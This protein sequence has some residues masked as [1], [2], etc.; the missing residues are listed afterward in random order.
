LNQNRCLTKNILNH[1]WPALFL[2]F[3]G[4]H[5]QST[6]VQGK[7]FSDRSLPLPFSSILLKGTTTGTTANT[8]GE[9][10]I[11]LPPGD[12][13]LIA[14][15]V[16][17]GSE[18]V[19]VHVGKDSVLLNF[20]LNLQQLTLDMITVKSGQEDPAYAIIREAIKKRPYYR[21]QEISYQC[22]VYTKGQIRLNSYPKIF[23]GQRIDFGD[24]GPSP[25]KM[26]YLSET[27]ARYTV[28][29]PDKE[30]I[31]VISTRVSGQSNGFGFSNPKV[32]SFYDNH[33]EITQNVNP[34]GFIS[35]IAEGAL[36]YYKYKY[37]GAFFEDGRQINRIQVIPK[38]DYEPLFSGYI[39][40]VEGEWRIHSL[41]LQL[42]K[43]S[44]LEFLRDI[45][46][47]Q[48]YMQV[49]GDI[50]MIQSQIVYPTVS[51]M[52]FDGH[53]FFTSVFSN[54]L[55]S[56]PIKKGFFD[57]T[58]I[59]YDS[60]SNK[61]DPAFWSALRPIPLMEDEVKDFNMKD[62]LEQKRAD[63]HY[64]D[65]LDKIRNKLTPV[66]LLLNGQELSRHSKGTGFQYDPLLKV[67]SF[68]TVEGWAIQLA[69]TWTKKWEGRR[70]L[71]ISPVIRYGLNNGHFNPLVIGEYKYG[72]KYVNTW[73]FS[74][75][76]RIFQFNNDNPIPQVMNTLTTLMD[77]RNY[78]KIYEAK[79]LSAEYTRGIGAGFT[80]R[81][82]FQYQ[83]RRPLENTDTTSYWGR[84]NNRENLTPN[85]PTEIA[86]SNM[87]PHEAFVLSAELRYRPGTR[88]IEMPDR[89]INIGS[90]YP[91]FTLRLDKGI[92]GLFG[93][94]VDFTKWQFTVQQNIN[95]KIPGEIR[96][97]AEWGGF[98]NKARAEIPDYI[99][100]NGNLTSKAENYLN[101]FQLLPYYLKSG[102][103]GFY[104]ALHAEH[105]F[106][107][108]L[109]NKIPYAKRL[110][111][112]LIAGTNLLWVGP[113]NH[114][115]ECFV[116]L[117]NIL[118]IFRV[119]YVWGWTE[120]GYYNQG[121][122][123]G[124]FAFNSL[125]KDY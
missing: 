104:T 123:I 103:Y 90:R 27:M 6:R 87:S 73:K 22:D 46:L 119:D 100:F 71:K 66:G 47:E 37:T 42:N 25:N 118:K 58:L 19:K 114:Y 117:D 96:Y 55:L 51:F 83:K 125:F 36:Q 80:I 26:I 110:N 92:K 24:G 16:G 112:R 54:Y 35:P 40:I 45:R 88:Y 34:R 29:P 63:P 59:R 98:L 78:M 56:P 111:L 68:N 43:S 32:I 124:I 84:H 60:L 89:K 18:E 14:R 41:Q 109:T 65:S 8:E 107:G 13:V 50:W 106:N 115:A 20:V 28:S 74:A 108:F 9:Y 21:R 38:R 33:V 72:I 39:N 70:Q 7:V 10:Y 48:L 4:A 69:G 49:K 17:Y 75:G 5:A 57:R 67:I 85:F 93:S 101:G 62:S 31:E 30:K 116:G 113:E 121:I 105:H 94:D 82:G 53:G 102:M 15:H 2:I 81:A 76:S 86:T 1:F 95:L 52:G 122:R 91:L 97:Q 12:H 120:K 44:Q 79:T 61:R 3:A 99:H 23:F 77:G 64:L 11:D